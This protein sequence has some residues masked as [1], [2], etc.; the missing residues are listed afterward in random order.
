[1]PFCGSIV[2]NHLLTFCT[3]FSG[4]AKTNSL[5]TFKENNYS[6]EARGKP[7]W[8]HPDTKAKKPQK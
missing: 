8:M 2:L 1:M 6:S 4:S 5:M 3:V 7:V